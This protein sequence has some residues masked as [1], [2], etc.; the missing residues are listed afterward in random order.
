MA[1]LGIRALAEN[2][3]R[4]V[5]VLGVGALG[6][7]CTA[8][9]PVRLIKA[10]EKYRHLADERTFYPVG[11]YRPFTLDVPYWHWA[12]SFNRVFAKL[13]RKPT[14]AMGSLGIIGYQTSLRMIDN[15]GLVH[16]GVAHQRLRSRGR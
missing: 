16:R 1:E 7:L 13:T 10:G 11:S 3:R 15:F 14:L 6:L 2:R 8:A 9:V 5:N 12:E 4:W